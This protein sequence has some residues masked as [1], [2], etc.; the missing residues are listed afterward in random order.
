MSQTPRER[1]EEAHERAITELEART[2]A[3]ALKHMS[4]EELNDV[5]K[6]IRENIKALAEVTEQDPSKAIT[7][8]TKMPME[9]KGE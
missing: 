6:S 8:V 3:K 5:M 1:L 4:L 9:E 2:D 7:V